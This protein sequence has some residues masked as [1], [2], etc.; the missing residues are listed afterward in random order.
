M[1]L[2]YKYRLFPTAAQR[3]SLQ[4]SL[5]ACRWVYNKSLETRKEAWEQR[6]ESV[7]RYDTVKMIP[8]WKRE[9]PFLNDAFSQ[10]LQETCTRLDLAF[11]AFFRRVKSGD[12][13]GYPR[14]RGRD[15]YDSFTYP[16]VGFSLLG[17][18]HLRLSKIG[19]VRIKMHRPLDGQCKTLTIR[20]DSI[21][22]WCACFSCVVEPNPLPPTDK[23]AGIDLGLTAFAVLSD[24]STIKRQRWMRRDERDIA[25]LQRKKERFARGSPE[26][27]KVIH[28]LRHAYE[29]AANRRRDFAHQ[30]SRKLVNMYQFVAF[31]DLDIQEMQAKDGNSN[32]IIRQGI[33]DVAW[34]RFMQ[35]TA[36]KAECAGRG[37]V[38]V[39][40]RGTTQN[41]SGCDQA[42]PKDLHV[43]THTCPHCGLSIGRDLNAAL[44]ILA[45]G[46]ASLDA[47]P[48]SSIV[49]EG[50]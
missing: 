35:F 19:D 18:S 2:T 36:Y 41:C 25:R 11:R 30:E 14:F 33:A 32:K 46:L 47:S 15:R 13:P 9:N 29:R 7:S 26:R 43:R 8:G 6:G 27:C 16:Q 39:D 28:A 44:N 37:V 3:T 1:R 21:G 31:E 22:N 17:D 12:E 42:V 48:R 45:R 23:V 34:G 4:K 20:R 24:G 38:F 5:D 40:P 49:Y 10:C 50:E